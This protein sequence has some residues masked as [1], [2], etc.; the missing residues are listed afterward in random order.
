MRWIFR[1]IMAL[2]LVAI[3]AVG[4]L[5]LLPTDRI[6][7][8]ASE[9]L[10]KATGRKLS[11]SGDFSPTL[12]PVIGVK[13]GR[14]TIS[15]ADWAQNPVMIEASGAAVGV[16]LS[17]LFGGN[18][19]VTKLQLVDPVIRLEKAGDGRVNWAFGNAG[20]GTGGPDAGTQTPDISLALGQITNGSVS[21]LDR[22]TGQT[23]TL[24]KI[25]MAISLPKG[26]SH[27][28]LDGQAVWQ[29]QMAKIKVEIADINKLLTDGVTGFDVTGDV[30]GATISALGSLGIGGIAPVVEGTISLAVSD[31]AKMQKML[32]ISNAIPLDVNEFKA[33]GLLQ[34]SAAG[35]YFS[36]DISSQVKD[37]PLKAT[38]ELTGEDDWQQTLSF[39]LNTTLLG[40]DTLTLGFDGRLNTNVQ[41]VQGKLDFKSGNPRRLF[42]AFDVSADLPK[43]TFQSLAASGELKIKSSGE[44]MLEKA[45]LAIDK[46]QLQGRIRISTAG[47]PHITAVLLAN[48]LNL[49]KFTSDGGG[50]GS[51][52]STTG[53][54]K[55]PI[56]LNG[57]DAVNADVSLKAKSVN[58]GVS[59]LGLVNIKAKLR[60][61]LLTLT[62]VDVRAYRGAMSGTVVVRGG[63]GVA[64]NSDVLAKD[65]Q[66]EPLLGQLLDIDRLI[67]TGTT[68]LKLSGQG[69]SLD[70]VMN[71]L[72]G[73][74]NIKFANGAFRGIDLAA[75]MKNL[76][77]A[78]GGFEGATEFSSMT[79]SFLL[80][81]GVLENVDLSL[82]SPLFKAAGK[83]KVGIGGQ[84][85]DYVVT[86]STLNGDAKVSVPV[87]ITGPWDNLKFRP[88][89]EKLLDLV[90]KGKL[91]E[92]EKVIEAKEKLKKLKD[93]LRDPEAAVKEKLAEKLK[94]DAANKEV[95]KN[96]VEQKIE[97]EIGNALKKLFD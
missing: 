11:L 31:I 91:E 43:G 56:A 5:F 7:Q 19:E 59:K 60:E 85:M 81:K 23:I 46:N 21:Y 8:I 54:S 67:G 62:L 79:G 12:Y 78:F 29:G 51:K 84:F 66:L 65:M 88:D 4:M 34:M 44:I 39:D 41:T 49:A 25:D 17:A 33:D 30:S 97:D 27:L 74:G 93:K 28:A 92:N 96:K 86:P 40:A 63:K 94:A 69:N 38:L 71:S 42:A 53:W 76:K 57:L 48:N 95:L 73:T 75:M 77:S 68:R 1:I 64:F 14:I 15:N 55:E 24:S 50:T 82:V 70:A 13:T 52:A 18:L 26:S 9:Q 32:G 10:E 22:Q 35:L 2:V 90:L 37:L 16:S 72:S 47:K 87:F 20:T 89:L 58:L 36:G 83:G 3:V 61:G 80:N 45:K 6:G